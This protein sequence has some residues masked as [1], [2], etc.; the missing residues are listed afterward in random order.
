MAELRSGVAW[1]A[2]KV[3][4]EEYLKVAVTRLL[5]AYYGAPPDEGAGTILRRMAD[6]FVERHRDTWLR[7]V[8]KT[9]HSLG[10]RDAFAALGR[11]VD[12]DGAGDWARSFPEAE[13]AEPLFRSAGNDAGVLS[14]DFERVHSLQATYSYVQCGVDGEALGQALAKRSYLWLRTQTLL[15]SINCERPRLDFEQAWVKQRAAVRMAT[16]AGYQVLLLRA[17]GLS[18]SWQAD[19]GNSAKSWEEYMQGLALYW[20]AKYPPIRAHWLYSQ[21]SLFAPRENAAY[22]AAAWARDAVE[23]IAPLGFPGYYASALHQLALTEMSLGLPAA[24]A[25]H[26]DRASQIT[27]TLPTSELRRIQSMYLTLELAEM[28]ANQGGVEGPLA[29]LATVGS[30]VDRGD[31]LLRLRFDADV[32]RLRLR[33]GEYAEAK[34]LFQRALAT[35]NSA[36]AGLSQEDRLSWERSMGQTY[37]ALVECEIRTGVSPSASWFL[38]SRY[39]SAL[40]DPDLEVSSGAAVPPGEAMLSFVELPSGLGVWLANAHGFRFRWLQPRT[41]VVRD[42]VSRLVRGC[43]TDHSPEPVL[44]EDARQISKWLIG[45]WEDELNGVAEVTIESDGA[46]ASVPWPALVRSNEHYWSQDFAVRIRVG[47]ASRHQSGGPLSAVSSI[48]AVGEPAVGSALAPL[49]EARLEADRVFSLFPRSTEL[50]GQQATLTAVRARLESADAFHFAG[51][52]YGGEGGGLILR[53]SADEPAMLKAA[54]IRD[55]HLSQCRLAV[56]SGCA[57]GT[58]ELNGP[59]D[60]QS[61]VRA[62]LRAGAHEVVASFWNLS[63]AGTQIF[64]DEFY[65]AL[66]TG[67]PADEAL[68]AA[69]ASVRAHAEYRHPYYWAGL[70]LFS[71]Q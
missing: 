44:R 53:G 38:W 27:A 32:G 24:A 59:G 36:H 19:I 69:A 61:L 10:A 71:V 70:Q 37:R 33:R 31:A 46:V 29:R 35:G 5:P 39:R 18:A 68:R 56:L 1:D 55:L 23:V 45:P 26:L 43:A 30:Q 15:A 60:P 50:V 16:E 63:S 20:T 52:G 51:H 25:G 40:F 65:T 3:P 34:K 54:D 7:D 64:M 67:T 12:A 41:D 17:L 49:P 58:G 57:T 28:E 22:S 47:N 8:I 14:A 9:S 4:D 6:A 21:L 2:L 62:F 13:R 66:R 42:G 48:L 11:A